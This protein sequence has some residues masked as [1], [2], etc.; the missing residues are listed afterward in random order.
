ML[1]WRVRLLLMRRLR[2]V[3]LLLVGVLMLLCWT[4]RRM[5]E[6]GLGLDRWCLRVRGKLLW[7]PV[8]SGVATM[9]FRLQLQ[10]IELIL[11]RR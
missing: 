5:M 10:H 2:G 11:G 6:E 8:L 4:L 1:L 3:V 7:L 9:V